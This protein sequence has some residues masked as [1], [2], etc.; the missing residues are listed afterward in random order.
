MD[1]RQKE[2][3]TLVKNVDEKT[4]DTRRKIMDII[5]QVEDV[6]IKLD[7]IEKNND[8][9]ES[10]IDSILKFYQSKNEEVTEEE[11]REWNRKNKCV[12]NLPLFDK[13]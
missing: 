11:K 7:S 12:S 13:L 6:G 4:H 10:K 5:G 1:T 8:M 2:T 3:R 9:I